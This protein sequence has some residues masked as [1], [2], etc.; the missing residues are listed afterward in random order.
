MSI[1]RAP[2][3][4]IF[5]FTQHHICARPN[6]FQLLAC[7][8]AIH[9]HVQRTSE[10]KA[11][12]VCTLHADRVVEMIVVHLL[13]T[14]KRQWQ[15]IEDRFIITYDVEMKVKI[16]SQYECNYMCAQCVYFVNSFSVSLSILLCS[17][18]SAPSP[19]LVWRC[20]FFLNL[21]STLTPS[22]W[23]CRHANESV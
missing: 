15:I 13:E 10:M 11:C 8:R 17:M 18:H 4:Y 12:V 6:H 14:E 3:F 21:Y 23:L 16:L 1:V 5:T 7:V 9:R 19:T 22:L 20:T 2:V